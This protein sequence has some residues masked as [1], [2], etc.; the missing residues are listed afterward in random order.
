MVAT[1]YPFE[2]CVLMCHVV[3]SSSKGSTAIITTNGQR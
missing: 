1:I 2:A 3:S